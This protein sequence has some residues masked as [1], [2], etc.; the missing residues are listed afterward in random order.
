MKLVR[1]ITVND[2]LTE[3][4][5]SQ[6]DSMKKKISEE[7]DIF[8][9]VIWDAFYSKNTK[10]FLSESERIVLEGAYDERIVLDKN[11]E[12]KRLHL[13]ASDNCKNYIFIEGEY[14]TCCDRNGSEHEVVFVE[15][16]DKCKQCEMKSRNS[17]NDTES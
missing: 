1:E 14:K 6:I 10:V 15:S 8:G 11:D 7:R 4:Q 3:A 13:C 16:P 17:I 2:K 5:F 9:N 12:I